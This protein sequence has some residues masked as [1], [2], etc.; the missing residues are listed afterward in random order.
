MKMT[1]SVCSVQVVIVS[2]CRF[3]VRGTLFL[4]SECSLFGMVCVWVMS[5]HR[6]NQ[7]QSQ[8]L[9]FNLSGKGSDGDAQR[10]IQGRK[11][12]AGEL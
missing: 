2:H 5:P 8:T 12:S 10:Q 3:Q 11:L 7:P 6:L 9:S 1:Q 4:V